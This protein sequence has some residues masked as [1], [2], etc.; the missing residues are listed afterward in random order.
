[1]YKQNHPVG[2]IIYSGQAS[3]EG[4]TELVGKFMTPQ[5]AKLSLLPKCPS[6]TPPPLY[7]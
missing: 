6:S 4:K 5:E 7:F 3:N 2:K 1:M